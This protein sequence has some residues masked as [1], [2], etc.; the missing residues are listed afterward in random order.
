MTVIIKQV[1]NPLAHSSIVFV[2]IN[3]YL[4]PTAHYQLI[5]EAFTEMINITRCM[6]TQN[7]YIFCPKYSEDLFKLISTNFDK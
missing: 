6:Y 1:L 7:I 3:Y 4:Y 2:N 5:Q